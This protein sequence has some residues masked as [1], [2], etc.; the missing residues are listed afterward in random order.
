MCSAQMGC[1]RPLRGPDGGEH[2]QVRKDSGPGFSR[3]G[4]FHGGM[5]LHEQALGSQARA[6]IVSSGRY[7]GGWPCPH[8]EPRFSARTLL[9]PCG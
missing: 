5:G 3:A 1:E 4:K 2:V 9:R 6:G 8:R 7:P